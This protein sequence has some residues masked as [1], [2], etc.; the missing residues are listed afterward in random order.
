M[1][2]LHTRRKAEIEVLSSLLSPRNTEEL[3]QY[4][5]RS[6]RQKTLSST[7]LVHYITN[8]INLVL[9]GSA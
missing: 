6:K 5:F 3:E 9:E 2:M 4:E 7:P 8:S 1:H